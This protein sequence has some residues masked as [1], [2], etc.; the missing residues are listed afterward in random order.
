MSQNTG[1]ANSKPSEKG[2]S[3]GCYCYRL[4]REP[5]ERDKAFTISI[6]YDCTDFYTKIVW[7]NNSHIKQ[8]FRNCNFA[9]RRLHIE[10]CT[11]V[12][13]LSVKNVLKEHFSEKK[14]YRGP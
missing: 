2:Y 9:L 8:S 13:R 11:C 7:E 14:A 12:L 6:D 5:E 1:S 4:A 10:A 3:Y